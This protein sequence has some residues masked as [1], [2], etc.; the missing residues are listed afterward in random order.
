MTQNIDIKPIETFVYDCERLFLLTFDNSEYEIN[1]ICLA[2]RKLLIDKPGIMG[3]WNSFFQEK[4]KLLSAT[5][6]DKFDAEYLKKVKLYIPLLD[7]LPSV[8]ITNYTSIKLN[9]DQGPNT[10][11]VRSSEI[12][13]NQV[14]IDKYLSEDFL[15]LD[16][17]YIT[18][19]DILEYIAYG[20]GAIHYNIRQDKLDIIKAVNKLNFFYAMGLEKPDSMFFFGQSFRT[21]EDK[22]RLKDNP[23]FSKFL[24]TL[25]DRHSFETL[26][27]LQIVHE[28]RATEQVM[29]LYN[30]AKDYLVAN[31][32]KYKDYDRNS[33][34]TLV[35]RIKNAR[36]HR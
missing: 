31:L 1:Q 20:I 14:S 10:Y 35:D 29:S 5:S 22:A 12:K 24:L 33:Y 13:I 2:V 16:G 32:R 28:I 30:K 34:F 19:K 9:E 11:S 6:S 3:F 26:M 18:R 27:A 17:K 4:F 23:E 36:Q 7:I 15:V 21:P 8:V 25:G